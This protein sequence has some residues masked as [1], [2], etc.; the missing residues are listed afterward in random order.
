MLAPLVCILKQPTSLNV[1]HGCSM[2]K[3]AKSLFLQ[4]DSRGRRMRQAEPARVVGLRY[5]VSDDA[6]ADTM[7][8][9]R[10]ALSDAASPLAGREF[11]VEMPPPHHGQAEFIVLRSR[12]DAAVQ[13][14]WHVND[15]C[16]VGPHAPLLCH[17][18]HSSQWQL[19]WKRKL[20]VPVE[21]TF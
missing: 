2:L 7:A 9:L 15:K 13:R 11:D 3:K 14:D 1:P 5:V 20:N 6:H 21:A 16:Q 10:L 18:D 19:S 17:D 12:F 8:V 4:A